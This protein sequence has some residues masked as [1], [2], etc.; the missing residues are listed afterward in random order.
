[1]PGLSEQTWPA[2]IPRGLPAVPLV[3]PHS[4]RPKGRQMSVQ[5]GASIPL[6]AGISAGLGMGGEQE[7]LQQRD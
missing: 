5:P 3:S 6:R 7:G 1:M 2:L 4:I